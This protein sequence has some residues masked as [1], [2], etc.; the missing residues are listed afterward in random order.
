MTQEGLDLREEAEGFDFV[1]TAGIERDREFYS[2]GGFK[3]HII[4][5][6]GVSQGRDVE[7]GG[8][9]RVKEHVC[10]RLREM[11]GN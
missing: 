6:G 11:Q 10:L 5:Q 9:W 4:A 2:L 3:L 1:D 8:V 7:K